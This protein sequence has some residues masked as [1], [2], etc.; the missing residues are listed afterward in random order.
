M[1]KYKICPKCKGEG[2]HTDVGFNTF[3]GV[4]TFG[5]IP[6][7]S[8]LTNDELEK[9]RCNKCKGRGKVKVAKV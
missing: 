6:I 7:L 2:E 4:M 9:C 3:V 8:W 5:M 1:F